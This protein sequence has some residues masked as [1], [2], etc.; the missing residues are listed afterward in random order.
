[1]TDLNRFRVL[2]GHNPRQ[3]SINALKE[4]KRQLI[5][6]HDRAI[7]QVE[8]GYQVDEGLMTGLRAALATVASGSV[9]ATK[10]IARKAAE[11][12]D[13]VKKL[14]QDE[15]AK[16][17]LKNMLKGMVAL[18]GKFEELEKDAPTLL[19]KDER[20]REIVKVFRDA[21][22]TMMTELQARAVPPDRVAPTLGESEVKELIVAFLAE[23]EELVEGDDPG[24]VRRVKQFMDENGYAYPNAKT[25][26]EI[27]AAHAE[28]C[29]RNPKVE[30]A[31]KAFCDML[32]I[33]VK[34]G[35]IE[36]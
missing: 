31:D 13:N 36:S 28:S 25:L 17:E 30:G 8:N 19:K 32:G 23:D 5:E 33:Q 11:L 1:M 7:K 3:D 29:K 22:Q 24:K 34:N 10:S 21:M 14:Y 27:K 26:D 20:V 35:K 15:K 4:S 6:A 12:G 16:I 18:A 2:A 9:K